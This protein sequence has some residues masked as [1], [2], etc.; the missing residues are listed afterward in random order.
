MSLVR[1]FLLVADPSG[2]RR[3]TVRVTGIGQRNA[4]GAPLRNVFGLGG[5]DVAT[6]DQTREWALE[7]RRVAKSD[8]IRDSAPSVT[9]H[10]SWNRVTK[11]T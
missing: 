3:W 5:S 1:D 9:C 8:L 11:S 4:K 7:W 10:H 6:L 2:V